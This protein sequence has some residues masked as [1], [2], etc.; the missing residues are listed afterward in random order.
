MLL[1][2][3]GVTLKQLYE[4]TLMPESDD[5]KRF[6]QAVNGEVEALSP[7][8]IVWKKYIKLIAPKVFY[9]MSGRSKPAVEFDSSEYSLEL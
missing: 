2:D 3:Y 8:E 7:Y 5:E 9:T 4:G 6:I 1:N